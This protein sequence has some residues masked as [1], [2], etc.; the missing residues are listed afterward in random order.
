MNEEPVLD[1]D[2]PARSASAETQ[3]PAALATVTSGARRVRE[4]LGRVIVGQDEA[5]DLALVTLLAGG[6]AL[7]EGVPGRGEDAAGEGAGPRGGRRISAHSVH[8]RLDAC[9]YHRHERLRPED[10]RIPPGARADFHQFL[11]GR[12]NQSRTGENTIGS[13]G[14]HARTA[15][16]DRS[17]DLRAAAGIRCVRNAKPDRASGHISASGGAEGPLSRKNSHGLSGGGRRKRTGAAGGGKA[18]RRSAGWQRNCARQ[19]CSRANWISCARRR[20]ACASA[21][22]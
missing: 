12:R 19:F 16:D 6:H 22:R 5:I 7:I 14:S 11:T 3:P 17:R 8:A 4:K 18:K 2:L 15:G 20:R 1:S 21:R 13:A 9:R 10:A